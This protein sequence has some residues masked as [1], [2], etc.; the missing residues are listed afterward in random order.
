MK[1]KQKAIF[2]DRDGLINDNSKLYYVYKIEDFKIN[3]GIF[4]CLDIFCRKNYKLIIVSNQGG[5]AKGQYT[6]ADVDKLNEHIKSQFGKRNIHITDIYYCPHHSDISRCLCRKPNSLMLEK[7]VAQHNI[8]IE[9]SFM[10]GDSERDIDAAE[11]IGIKGIKTKSNENLFDFLKNSE[12]A[13]L[14]E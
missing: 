5:I 10:I 2:L 12:Y 14:L 8:N 1:I 11:R 3:D 13:Y 4:E 6:T 9:Q 7:A